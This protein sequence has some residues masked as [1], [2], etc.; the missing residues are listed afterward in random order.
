MDCSTPGLPTHHNSRSLL[1]LM[2]I[3]SAMPSNLLI[4]CRPLLLPPSVFP[5]IRVFFKDCSSP[6][7]SFKCLKKKIPC[8]LCFIYCRN[9]YT[10]VHVLV[11]SLVPAV[12][13]LYSFKTGFP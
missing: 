5:S 13:F 7:M 6:W 8:F 1:K 11:K 9:K 12:A 10:S 3:E 2:P 4:L